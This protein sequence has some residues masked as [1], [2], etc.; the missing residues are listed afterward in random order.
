MLEVPPELEAD[1]DADDDDDEEG[2]AFVVV[3]TSIDIPT[4]WLH[5]V[6]R[7]RRLLLASSL[8]CCWISSLRF[9]N[10]MLKRFLLS[11]CFGASFLTVPCIDDGAIAEEL[12]DDDDDE[13]EEDEEDEEEGAAGGPGC[14]GFQNA[15]VDIVCRLMEWKCS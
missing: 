7:S 10:F 2:L 6:S 8:V 15:D 1:D 9:M 11:S 4:S 5:W 12:D 3:S 13:D 14:P